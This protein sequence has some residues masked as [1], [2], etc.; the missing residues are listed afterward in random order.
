MSGRNVVITGS[1]YLV[2]EAETLLDEREK[3][4]RFPVEIEG[5]Q[6]PTELIE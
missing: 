4:E 5:L 3:S 1:L 6:K 2:G